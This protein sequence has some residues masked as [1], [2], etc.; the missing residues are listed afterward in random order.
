MTELE[1]FKSQLEKAGVVKAAI[2]ALRYV[3]GRLSAAI[4]L[5]QFSGN[6]PPSGYSGFVEVT[7]RVPYVFVGD[8][9]PPVVLR[10]AVPHLEAEVVAVLRDYFLRYVLQSTGDGEA[11]LAGVHDKTAPIGSE[12]NPVDLTD[13]PTKGAG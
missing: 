8:E 12:Q 4:D 7:V 3:G 5:Q 9:P 1:Y 10:S 2:V 13:D 11:P 6:G